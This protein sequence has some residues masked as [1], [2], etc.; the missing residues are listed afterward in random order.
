[1]SENITVTC[2]MELLLVRA[3]GATTVPHLL[4]R[5][6]SLHVAAFLVSLLELVGSF[7]Q[8]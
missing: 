4:E 5:P 6:L 2:F 1:M 8:K 7:T 3:P